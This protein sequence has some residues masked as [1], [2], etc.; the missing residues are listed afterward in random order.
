[1][2][3]VE[4]PLLIIQEA[5]LLIVQEPSL[6][7]VLE[8]APDHPRTVRFDNQGQGSSESSRIILDHP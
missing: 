1:M 6:L 2:D 5:P 4:A 3:N 8:G 7:I